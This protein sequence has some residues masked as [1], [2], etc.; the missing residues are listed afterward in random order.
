MLF[1]ILFACL[2]HQSVQQ[3]R[4]RYPG[5]SHFSRFADFLANLFPL[6]CLVFFDGIK[7]S[8]ALPKH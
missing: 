1:G 5:S 7:K 6:V 4:K 2:C 8:L 3:F